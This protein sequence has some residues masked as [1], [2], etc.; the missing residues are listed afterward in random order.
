MKLHLIDDWR[1]VLR[2]AWSV[3]LGVLSVIFTAAEILLP[4]YSDMFPRHVFATLSVFSAV[5]GLVLRLV[6]QKDFR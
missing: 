6:S 3:R 2:R 1:K 5:G 4:L